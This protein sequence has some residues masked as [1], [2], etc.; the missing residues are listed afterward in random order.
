MYE[1]IILLLGILIIFFFGYLSYGYIIFY[2]IY[3]EPLYNIGSTV[4][5]NTDD[6]DEYITA[7]IIKIN[8]LHFKRKTEYSYVIKG[9]K[10][11]K[12]KDIIGYVTELK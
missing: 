10:T 5:I 12:E 2:R 11:Y 4:M 6:N 7:E 8:K 3:K 9:N 1:Y